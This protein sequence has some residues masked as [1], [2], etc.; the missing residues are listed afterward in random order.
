[1][2]RVIAHLDMDAFFVEV[3]RLTDPALVGKCVIVG[4]DPDGRGVV[5]SA[6][7]E[8][9]A[10]GVRSAMPMSR[11]K[12]LCP[13]AA[14]V[15]VRTSDYGHYSRLVKEALS[16]FSPLV[17]MRSIDE[18]YIDL[19]GSERLHGAPVIA[20]D[21]LRAHVTEATGL[22]CSCGVA[23]NKLV[24]KVAS[25]MAK[26]NGL[27]LVQPGEEGATLAPLPMRSLP[28][29]GARLAEKLERYGLETLGDIQQLGTEAL[30]GALGERTGLELH[31][32]VNG[33]DDSPVIVARETK[34][35]SRETTF[36]ED[37]GH[38][39]T[40]EST[41]SQLSE[42]VARGLRKIGCRA[43]T[44][45]LKVRYSDFKTITRSFT[46]GEATA[47]D[48][49]IFH[50]ARDKLRSI[51]ERRV[52]VRLLGVGG[53]NLT[54]AQWQLDFLEQQRQEKDQRLLDAVDQIKDRY[55][56][57]SIMRALSWRE[58]KDS[59]KKDS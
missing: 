47:D 41:L 53:T 56:S 13:H 50:A 19:T 3:E 28:G 27:R 25:D 21:K 15:R 52:R 45:T 23:A 43:R 34:S 38:W 42:H 26:P 36:Q 59:K 6:S 4:G 54:D 1:M 14:F 12:R 16:D 55:G 48:R 29:I 9:R 30:C 37:T 2:Q 8:A 46:L 58:K 33:Q 57:P 24:A 11:A 5:C 7:Y 44:I 32:R 49:A 18:A 22:P 10:F 20:A 35:V 39:P 51:L 40:L 17:E 31:N